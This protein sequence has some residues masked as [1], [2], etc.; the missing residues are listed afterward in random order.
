MVWTAYLFYS[1]A[2]LA[3]AI[4]IFAILNRPKVFFWFWD[5]HCFTRD[6]VICLS[7]VLS[8]LRIFVL[9]SMYRRAQTSGALL[10]HATISS[11]GYAF[12]NFFNQTLMICNF[13][14]FW[15]IVTL[16]II[17]VLLYLHFV[18]TGYYC[19]MYVFLSKLRELLD[20]LLLSV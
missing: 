5:F 8:D 20:F 9:F 1:L 2:T 4:F 17:G 11:E 18:L 12:M 14:N 10:Q 19:M 13:T 7:F 16:L 15:M 6:I 3:I